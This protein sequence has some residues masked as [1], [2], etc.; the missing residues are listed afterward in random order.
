MSR[1]FGLDAPTALQAL[2]DT[3]GRFK[4]DLLNEDLA[5]DCAFKAWQLCDH[6]Y[7]VADAGAGILVHDV[8]GAWRATATAA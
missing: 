5:R 7:N 1:S 4:T 8:G 2:K 3:V 6:A